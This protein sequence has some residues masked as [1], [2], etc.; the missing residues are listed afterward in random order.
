MDGHGQDEQKRSALNDARLEVSH[1]GRTVAAA[2][3]TTS[4]APHGVATVVLRS[5]HDDLATDAR[6]ELVDQVMGHP[7]VRNSDT[8]HVV[9]PMG[10]SESI[11]RLQD[12][13]ANFTAR[14]AGSSSVVEA[15]VVH[16]SSADD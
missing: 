11:S 12:H 6:A 13:T 1:E 3:I 16:P 2:D 14:A 15:E 10:D 7:G 5:S 9:V 8:V 4:S